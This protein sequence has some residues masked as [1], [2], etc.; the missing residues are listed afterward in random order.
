MCYLIKKGD[1]R[2]EGNKGMIER[3]EK[4]TWMEESQNSINDIS[5][6]NAPK[7]LIEEGRQAIW[8]KGFVGA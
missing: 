3:S 7:I 8:S 2:D 4:W 5:F 6:N 1:F